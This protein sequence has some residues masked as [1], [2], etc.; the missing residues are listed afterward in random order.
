MSAKYY[1][2][3]DKLNLTHPLEILRFFYILQQNNKILQIILNFK[4]E[5][6]RI[7]QKVFVSYEY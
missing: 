3:L 2:A 5:F 7:L 1:F 6:F 4:K